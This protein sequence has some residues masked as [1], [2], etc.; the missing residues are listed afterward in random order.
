MDIQKLK[1]ILEAFK[2]K[3]ILVI[4]DVMLD[5]Y[6]HG[7]VE[8]ISPE[9]PV[10]VLEVKKEEYRL[11]GS[12]NVADNLISLGA[13]VKIVG[14][15]GDDVSG[16][17]II[18]LFQNKGI[19]TTGLLVSNTR[20][21]TLKTRI[22]AHQQQIVRID[23]EEHSDISA[24]LERQVLELIKARITEVDAIIIEDYNKGLLT[25]QL[26][27]SI[28]LIGNK[29]NKPVAVDPKFKNFFAYRNCTIFKPNFAELQKNLG[30]LIESEEQFCEAVAVLEEKINAEFLVITRGEKG[31]SVFSHEKDMIS[32]PTFAREIYDVSGAGDT[33]ISALTLGLVSDCDVRTAA[34]L[35]NHAAGVVCGKMG[36]SVAYPQEIIDSMQETKE[37]AAT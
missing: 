33:V 1:A 28:I 12:G 21:T 9:A 10:P 14:L 8:R 6:I 32:I 15:I 13:G 27:E 37:R 29:E 3:K 31:L 22:I 7:S 34:T 23:K 4:G 17:Q 36:T 25:R 18:K 24:E 19:D 2:Q 35:A 20:P 16:K 30:I 26:I 11:G 5:H